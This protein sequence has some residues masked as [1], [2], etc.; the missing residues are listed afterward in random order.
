ML[1]NLLQIAYNQIK[2]YYIYIYNIYIY[3]MLRMMRCA[4]NKEFTCFRINTWNVF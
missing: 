2:L 3:D 4:K 1:Y